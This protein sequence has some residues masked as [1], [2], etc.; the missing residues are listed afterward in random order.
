M[1]KT[2][3][4]GVERRE[5]GNVWL[6][7]PIYMLI[8]AAGL[9]FT[10]YAMKVSYSD[11]GFLPKILPWIAVLALFVLKVQYLQRAE[12]APARRS[13]VRYGLYLTAAVPIALLAVYTA[14]ECRT[15][16]PVSL[17]LGPILVAIAE[18]GMYRGILLPALLKKRT[19]N[20]AVVR[21]A[22][23]FSLLHLLNLLGG[24]SLR[25]VGIQLVLT[26]MTGLYYAAVYM[27]TGRL[28][29]MILQHALWDFIAFSGVVER[30][31]WTGIAVALLTAM[32][33]I[34]AV[35]LL[36]SYRGK[37][38]DGE[39]PPDEPAYTA[40]VPFNT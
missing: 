14:F 19:V 10:K 25:A 23:W 34:F 2:K 20:G 27:K 31:P 4:A 8:M 24:Q 6:V 1:R 11:P 35:I 7:L 40:D 5:N 21:C 12:M 22:V 3:N 39:F 36:V 28:S 29:L 30:A 26:F 32:Q 18:E 9:F 17:L 33:L 13:P 15:E 38:E 37:W 16:L